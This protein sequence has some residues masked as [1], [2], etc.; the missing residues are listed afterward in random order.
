MATP[1]LQHSKSIVDKTKDV[2]YSK[3]ATR[4]TFLLSCLLGLFDLFSDWLVTIQ[5]Y[6][7]GT[8]GWAAT[9]TFFLV[10]HNVFSLLYHYS[11]HNATKEAQKKQKIQSL[12]KQLSI[13]SSNSNDNETES[14]TKPIPSTPNDTKTQIIAEMFENMEY[15]DTNNAAYW[16]FPFFLLGLGAYAASYKCLLRGESNQ[17]FLENK[18]FEILFESMPCGMITIFAQITLNDYSFILIASICCSCISVGFGTAT[19]FSRPHSKGNPLEFKPLIVSTYLYILFG[20]CTTCDY[21][22][23]VYASLII[24]DVFIKIDEINSS[25]KLIVI[26]VYIFLMVSIEVYNI[27]LIHGDKKFSIGFGWVALYS[28]SVPFF[29]AVATRFKNF[30][31]Y[32]C[33]IGGRNTFAFLCMCLAFYLNDKSYEKDGVTHAMTDIEKTYYIVVMVSL[34]IINGIAFIHLTFKTRKEVL[35][36]S[37]VESNSPLGTRIHELEDK[38]SS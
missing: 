5:F 23:R 34:A 31:Y 29:A 4:A 32:W 21:I 37:V 6:I 18:Y 22:L 2:I 27:Y 7:N 20:L 19:Y 28:N 36:L 3:T 33:E 14:K 30:G 38:V 35:K 13:Y 10:F 9:L 12:N 17:A 24:V 26:I 15:D 11:E 25:I 8:Y 16:Q 1:D